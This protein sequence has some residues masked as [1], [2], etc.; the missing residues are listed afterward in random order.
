MQQEKTSLMF[1]DRVGSKPQTA[2]SDMLHRLRPR[3]GYA[4]L[5][6]LAER[7]PA[8]SLRSRT[9]IKPSLVSAW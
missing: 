6:S 7:P 5:H 9:R 3:Y 4:S 2:R 1:G 8:V